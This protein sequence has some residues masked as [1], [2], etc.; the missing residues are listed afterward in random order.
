MTIPS[1]ETFALS[2]D[3][4]RAL[5]ALRAGGHVF[6][7]GVAGTGKSAVV[8]RWLAE[9]DQRVAVTAS[10][11]V[12]A[13][14]I[15]GMTLHSWAGLGLGDRPI[16]DVVCRRWWREQVAS[17]M[18]RADALLI[19]EVSM[20]DAGTLDLADA[21]CRHARRERL[22]PFGGLQVV[23]VG[24]PGQLPPV[25]LADRGWPYDSAAWRALAP[26]THELVTVHRQSDRAFVR[27]L[28]EVRAGAM[29]RS[30]MILL[31]SRVLAFDPDL[32]GAAR[33]M[34]HN[35]Q[36]DGVNEARLGEL[37]GPLA[38]FVAED[39][40]DPRHLEQVKR[41]CLSPEV[42]F[43]R[44]GA[45]VMATKNDPESG[46]VN[47]SLGVVEHIERSAVRVRFIGLGAR[48]VERA[49]WEVCDGDRVLASRRQ[50]PLRLAWAITIHKSQGATLDR[51]SVNLARAFAPGQA[52]VALSRARTIDGLNLEAWSPASVITHPR[53]IQMLGRGSRRASQNGR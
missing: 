27:A 15:S 32:A 52:Y 22:L 51:V 9:T 38:R 53:I 28:A 46:A 2:P 41:H 13:L 43:L 6:L 25:E 47:G 26:E 3:Q 16:E 1:T 35:E 45:R 29:S 36:V 34:T 12:A 49:S 11:G 42:L 48:W 24:D 44:V 10:T 21:L 4:E 7:T 8:R 23:L 20:L 39:A 50:I 33:L 37:D 17:R 5:E 19:D 31:E 18:L 30:T 14:Q 40:G